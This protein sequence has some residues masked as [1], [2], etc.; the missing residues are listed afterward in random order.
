MPTKTPNG[1]S[2]G[3]H[4]APTP[5]I[6]TVSTRFVILT[7]ASCFLLAF[8]VGRATRMLLMEGPRGALLWPHLESSM[9]NRP[10]YHLGNRHKGLPMPQMMDDKEVPHTVYTS[11]NFD[12][13]ASVTSSSILIEKNRV[14]TTSSVSSSEPQQGTCASEEGSCSRGKDPSTI[15]NEPAESENDDE[16]E[17]L[18]AGQHLL[19]DIKDVD[20]SFLNSE[21]RLAQAMVDVVN[22]SK[23]TLLSY[24]CHTL[25]PV[26]VS[27][28]GVLLESHVSF[29]TWPNDGVITLDLFTCG[30]GPLLPVLPVIERL[31]A[32]PR[33]PLVEGEEVP[34]PGVIWSHKL[35][36]FRAEV[37]HGHMDALASPDLGVE[38]LGS[39]A[40]DLKKELVSVQT[41]F[42]RIDIYDLI[43]PLTRT[44][45]SYER[46]L[47]ND[48]SYESLHHELYRPNKQI[49]L[50]GVMQ[51]TLYGDA[52]Y[53]ESLVHPG[54]FAH[55]D[56]RRVA[57]IGGGEG[58]TLRE[59]LKHST[60]EKCTMIEIDEMMVK[61]S[62]EYLKEWS[63][64][65]DIIGSAEW[66]VEDPR[67]DVRYEDAVA[68][69]TDRFSKDEDGDDGKEDVEYD[70]DEY[71]P[72]DVIIMDAL[73]PQM[74]IP[75]AEVLYQ[76]PTFLTSIYNA[77]SDEGII[78][79]QL[80]DAPTINDPSDEIG[81]NTNRAK[82]TELLGKVGFESM[83]VYEEF[84]S[85]FSLPWS[86]L[87]AMKDYSSRTNWYQNAAEVEAAI[88]YRIKRTYSGE[89]A[90]RFFDGATMMS[91][92]VPNKG[93]ETVYCRSHPTPEGCKNEGVFYTAS[94]TN[95]KISSFEVKT[96]EIGEHAGRGVFAKV[97]IPKGSRIALDESVKSIYAAPSTVDLAFTFLKEFDEAQDLNAATAYLYGYGFVSLTYG[98]P[99]ISV[100][101]SIM[102]FVN[103]GCN[104]THNMGP[105]NGGTKLTE[106]SASLDSMPG[107]LRDEEYI[108]HDIV[109][110][111]HLPH[112]LGGGDFALCDIKAGEEILNN[113]LDFTANPDNWSKD[114][115][116]LRDQC[117]NKGTGIVKD[118]ED[119]K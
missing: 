78:V 104:G 73:D 41:P 107:D 86:Y 88:H 76:D 80:G 66:C 20:G 116:D 17:H 84:H 83:H 93:F 11:K 25:V 91:F 99:S 114:L 92:Q 56:P 58:A 95:T 110:A 71:K 29:H 117:A 35:R 6:V 37:E 105:L 18:P 98:M 49:F 12:T 14:P 31:F 53:H 47:S 28:V 87:V 72:F 96:S 40:F 69:F 106:L 5:Y 109:S 13:A 38:V 108:L 2:A 34:K 101:S 30:S 54:M 82:I 46:S 75:F 79:M 77:L 100:D 89:S 52:G 55:S 113:Y 94:Y 61:V 43:V 19:V 21:E 45:A 26:G 112:L 119:A 57:I 24:H 102:T 111:R 44:L 33:K 8:T 118:Y 27:C 64:C 103:H 85:G 74:K 9:R 48:G 59:V 23:L 7:M 70:E 67:A 42:Q 115:A 97:D 22:D 63:D 36:G 90:L 16:E 39:S 1:M 51:S 4:T 68:W 15:P 3:D 60:V 81:R 50:D 32:V 10:D 65:S 62:H